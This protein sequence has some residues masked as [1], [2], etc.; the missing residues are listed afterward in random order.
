MPGQFQFRLHYIFAGSLVITTR[1]YTLPR[2]II[3]PSEWPGTSEA[4]LMGALYRSEKVVHYRKLGD[5]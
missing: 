1:R 2:S 3:A 5:K 4:V